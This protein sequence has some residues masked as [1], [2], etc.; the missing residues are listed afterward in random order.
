MS[1]LGSMGLAFSPERSPEPKFS[2]SRLAISDNESIETTSVSEFSDA[3][4]YDGPLL[5]LSQ[6]QKLWSQDE[7][8]KL[9][10]TCAET[11]ADEQF[12]RLNNKLLIA[13]KAHSTS[14]KIFCHKCS[15]M[16]LVTK[17]GKVN[18]TYQ[19]ACGNHTLSA[20]QILFTL[21][22]EFIQENVP[23]NPRYVFNA[24]I[25]WIGKDH[26]SPELIEMDTKRKA[27]KRFSVYRSPT[28]A[29]STGLIRSRNALNETISEIKELKSRLGVSDRSVEELKKSI[30]LLISQNKQLMENN[31]I[32]KEENSVLKRH[33]HGG[34]LLKKESTIND[35]QA[36]EEI[37]PSPKP[38]SYASITDMIKPTNGI[39]C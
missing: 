33:L 23:E 37:C 16:R 25:K 13:L 17:R 10:A 7:L 32:L 20:T 26:L 21:P 24:T 28:K 18:K 35:A 4:S 19:F 38:S 29:P 9:A 36:R 27:V 5:T 34:K 30:E 2:V 1:G 6:A 39:I 14:N 12:D 3:E 15:S 11:A 31:K 8:Q 22:D